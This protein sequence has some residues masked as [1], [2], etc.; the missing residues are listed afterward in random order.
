MKKK[1]ENC[2]TW[3]LRYIQLNNPLRKCST[4]VP[5][6][7]MICKW[8]IMKW[9]F[10]DRSVDELFS[11]LARSLLF[12]HWN[13][14]HPHHKSLA[15]REKRKWRRKSFDKKKAKKFVKQRRV[16]SVRQWKFKNFA[17]FSLSAP[18]RGIPFI[19]L[20]HL[21]WCLLPL[22]GSDAKSKS[23]IG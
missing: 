17:P 18:A 11:S 22:N 9:L 23:E 7:S 4:F 20:F 1:V 21:W 15:K 5:L 19:N 16:A 3:Q 10:N 13:C 14:M 6:L 2:L 8:K 12:I